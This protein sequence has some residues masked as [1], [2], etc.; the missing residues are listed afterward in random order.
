M[1]ANI[2]NKCFKKSS[3]SSSLFKEGGRRENGREN[4]QEQ[5]EPIEMTAMTG[6]PRA[7]M[8]DEDLAGDDVDVY[9]EKKVNFVMKISL[10]LSFSEYSYNG[11][12]FPFQVVEIGKITP[13][14][15]HSAQKVFQKF[16]FR[17]NQRSSS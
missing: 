2:F 6:T 5:E 4:R 17:K 13:P 9:L 16:N 7:K 1:I 11:V 15:S 12:N 8:V 14:S 10:S 3:H